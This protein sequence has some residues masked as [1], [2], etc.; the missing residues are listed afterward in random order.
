MHDDLLHTIPVQYNEAH[1]CNKTK[2][3]NKKKQNNN[4]QETLSQSAVNVR[5]QSPVSSSSSSRSSL[6]QKLAK[7]MYVSETLLVSTKS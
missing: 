4:K 2:K 7:A 5:H 6:S 3:T 1:G